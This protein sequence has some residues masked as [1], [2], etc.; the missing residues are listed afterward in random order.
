MVTEDDFG[1]ETEVLNGT[2]LVGRGF[3]EFDIENPDRVKE[4]DPE[5]VEDYSKKVIIYGVNESPPIHIMLVC[6]LQ[7]RT[8]STCIL[9]KYVSLYNT[10]VCKIH[11]MIYK[12]LRD[13]SERHVNRVHTV[14]HIYHYIL[15][16]HIRLV[17][18]FFNFSK[19]CQRCQG[20]W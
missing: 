3:T 5:V 11:F 20:N 9:I 13:S 15:Y 2:G 10:C 14:W 8:C 18:F 1:N 16:L 19:D 6:A 17:F 7:V 4:N 12:C